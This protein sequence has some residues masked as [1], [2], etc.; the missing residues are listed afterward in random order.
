MHISSG[1]LSKLS[2][3]RFL[4]TLAAAFCFCWITVS[5][6][7]ILEVKSIDMK[8]ADLLPYL[9]TLLIILSNIFTFYFNKKSDRDNK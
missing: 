7:H 5:L 4:L 3:G 1:L 8:M 6:V 2:S 9:S